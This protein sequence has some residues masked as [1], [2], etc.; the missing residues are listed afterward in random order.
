MEIKIKCYILLLTQAIRKKIYTEHNKKLK[1]S[2]GSKA[3]KKREV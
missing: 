2:N 3:K 1:E